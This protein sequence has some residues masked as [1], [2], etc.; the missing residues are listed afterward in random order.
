MADAHMA[1][2][3][4]VGVVTIRQLGSGGSARIIR[5][6]G[7]AVAAHMPGATGMRKEFLKAELKKGPK[8]DEQG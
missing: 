8:A 2:N 7:E 5:T 1:L 4:M 6:S 3:E